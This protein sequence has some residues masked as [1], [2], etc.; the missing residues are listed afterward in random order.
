VVLA[1]DA[2]DYGTLAQDSNARRL[3]STGVD[4]VWTDDFSDILS[5]FKW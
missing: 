4:D 5:V 2:G 3:V 1:R